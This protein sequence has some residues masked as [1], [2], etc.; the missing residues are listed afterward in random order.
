MSIQ[1]RFTEILLTLKD[2]I[3]D[4]ITFGYWSRVRGEE[5]V[6]FKVKEG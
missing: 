1:D 2:R 4:A 3:L 5:E 6:I